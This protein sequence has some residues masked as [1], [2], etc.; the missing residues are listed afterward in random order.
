MGK[1]PRKRTSLALWALVGQVATGDGDAGFPT[2]TNSPWANGIGIVGARAQ[3]TAAVQG[4]WAQASALLTPS[5]DP[6]LLVVSGRTTVAGQTVDSAPSTS[7]SLSLNL[8]EAISD[9]SHPPWTDLD[10]VGPISSYASLVPLSSSAALFYG[11]DASSDPSV[12]VQTGSD[13]SWL[14]SLPSDAAT[15]WAHETSALWPA[16]PQRRESAYTASATNGTLSR[17]WLFG[18]RRPDGSG[19]TFDELWELQVPVE[20]ASGAVEPSSARWAAWDGADGP[21]AMYDGAAVLVPDASSS[22]AMPSVY[23]LGGVEATSGTESAVSFGEVW[24]FTPSADEIGGGSWEQVEMGGTAPAGRRGH[25]AV[26]VGEGKIWIQGGRSADGTSVLRDAWVLDTRKKRWSRARD[27][28]QVWGHSAAMVGETV[29]LTFG[30]G[31][32]APASTALSVYAP[33]NNTWLSAY[34]PSYAVVVS[35]P[36]AGS[37]ASSTV[38]TST[39]TW[40]AADQPTAST[41]APTASSNDGGTAPENASPSSPDSSDSGSKDDR[42]D[43]SA[44]PEWTAPGSAGTGAPDSSGSSSGAGGKGENGSGSGPSGGTIAG[45]V[46]GSIIGALALGVGAAFA[47][48]RYRDQQ[49]YYTFGSGAGLTGDDEFGGSGGGGGSSLMAEHRLHGGFANS[50][51]YNVGKALPA[52]PSGGLGSAAAA[53]GIVGALAGLLSPRE[54][55][56]T[57][58]ASPIAGRRRRFDMLKD[59]END[60]VWDA[61]PGKEGWTRFEDDEPAESVAGTSLSGRG[62]MGIW[63]GF[64]G[65]APGVGKISD[66]L[67]SS[68]SYLGGALGGFIGVARSNSRRTPGE[69]DGFDDVDLA[70]KAAPTQHRY[71]EIGFGA[72][73]QSLDPALTPIAEYEEDEDIRSEHDDSRTLESAQTH[74]SG[75]H[76]TRSTQPTSCEVTP[77]KGAAR[78]SRPF[79]PA[80]SL[81]GSGFLAQPALY[82]AGAGLARTTSGQSQASNRFIS[83]SNSSW[84]SR[85][86][87]P[88]PGLSGE[89]PTPTASEAIRDPAPAPSMDAISA[90]DPFVDPPAK[91]PTQPAPS[92]LSA[93][94]SR[95]S[96]YRVTRPDE[97]GRFGGN[98][99]L[100][101]GEHDASLSSNTSEVTA[102]SSVLEERLRNMDVVQR[103]RTGSGGD[104]STEVTPT[105]GHTSDGAFGRLPDVT[106]DPFA[107]APAVVAHPNRI[108]Y[109]P[110]QDSVV[111]AGSVAGA[112]SEVGAPASARRPS[113]PPPVPSL[114]I[115]VVPP[116]P[117]Y[118]VP[119][120]PRRRLAGPRPQPLSPATAPTPFSLPRSNSVKDL[121]AT[122]ERRSSMHGDALPLPPTASRAKRTKVEH[123]LVRKPQLYV[124]NPDV[125]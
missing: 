93:P 9:L 99:H 19:T 21:P 95:Q 37:S 24:V 47:Y 35:N 39:Q 1:R 108:S 75:T 85:L 101:R 63:D 72:Q 2:R 27:G 103:V 82:A 18:G 110:A 4:R 14:L 26:D 64:G 66:S 38:P 88:K 15:T 118:A 114:P 20:R 98:G 123:G 28:R 122:I 34:V 65:L 67:K 33:G 45:A 7:T 91:M 107:D 77:T 81:Y 90:S 115:A 116:T 52:T 8:A 30:Y 104:S 71:A 121:V 6:T 80:T 22:R 55:N 109:T 124:A 57:A 56:S 61:G 53:G 29:V 36:K 10:S 58:G 84:W 92:P 16:Q 74:S 3:S 106:E 12:S 117:T 43:E 102:T 97:H 11:G 50:D 49:R 25:V 54:R 32:N 112:L 42:N 13:S 83:R 46:I 59:E 62:G 100:V 94:P 40:Y 41:A 78:I 89:V 68:T 87:L 48:K 17:A 111:W 5:N 86:N 44:S 60:D 120:S 119:D 96:S 105:I 69:E 51:A 76:Q 113:T 70:E 31:P 125:D 23:L 79:S 73:Q